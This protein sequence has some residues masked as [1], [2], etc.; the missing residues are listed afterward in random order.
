MVSDCHSGHV[1]LLAF[2]EKVVDSNCSIEEAVL[3]MHVQMHIFC[4]RV[5]CHSCVPGM[6][7][8]EKS[9]KDDINLRYG[10]LIIISVYPGKYCRDF[11]KT[12]WNHEAEKKLF[13]RGLHIKKI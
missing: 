11:T 8:N 12:F 6:M 5:L 13:Q 9:G 1:Q 4:G 3:G 10:F 7:D 2:L